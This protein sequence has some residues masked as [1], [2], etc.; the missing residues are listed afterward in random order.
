[1]M[2][3]H[4]DSMRSGGVAR[5]PGG[6][7]VLLVATLLGA[8][9]L[10]GPLAT[11]AAPTSSA[12]GTADQ[13]AVETLALKLLASPEVARQKEET[14]K[15][16]QADATAR[17]ADGKATV[18]NAVDELAFAAALGAANDD[19]TH[20]KATW[21]YT[22]PRE[23]FG[24]QV[25]GSRWGIDNPDNVYRF[26]RVD[27]S[28]KYRIRVH[29]TQ[30][31]PVQYSFLLYDTFIGENTRQKNLDEPIAGLRDRDIKA[32]ADGS[33]VITVDSDP[34]NGRPN[35]IQTTAD[36]KILLVRN[37]FDDWGAQNPLPLEIERIGGPEARKP[38][39]DS[40]LARTAADYLKAGTNTLLELENGSAFAGGQT[41]NTLSK[42]FLRGGN[43]GFASHGT[44][45]L[46]N[47]EALLVTLD[48][49]GAKYL[50]FDVTDPWLV[51]R[52]HIRANGSLNNSQARPNADGTFTYVVSARDPGILNWLDTGG[53]H[54]GAI[55]IRWQSLP[56]SVKSAD[57]AVRDVKVVKLADLPGQLPPETAKVTPEERQRLY[58]ERAA[59]Y[60]HRYGPL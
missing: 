39:S 23:W 57:G 6:D 21:A 18:T 51:S 9:F 2:N 27:G 59:S 35:H 40:E 47:D 7:L 33:F 37:T 4:L 50:G 31:G 60:A 49:V 48:P 26:I 28:S 56:E 17:T 14:L 42:P 10:A 44:F 55:L 3:S 36:A 52:E 54:E 1:M 32:E 12:L 53:L 34:A 5:S 24:Y 20:P 41:V 15:R 11:A 38:A 43:W 19:P 16:F 46:G 45:K 58:A 13:Q 8:G 29:P 22:A 30:P 25:P